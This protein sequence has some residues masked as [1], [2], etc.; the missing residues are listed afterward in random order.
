MEKSYS[1]QL[2]KTHKAYGKFA[3]SKTKPLVIVVHGLPCTINE[4]IYERAC[5]YFQQAGYSTYRF[6]LYDWH[7]DARQLIDCTLA[8]HATDLDTVVAHFRRKGYKKIFVAGHSFGGPTILLSKKQ[9]F[10]AAVLWDPSYDVS[11]IKKK[12]GAPGG[13]FVKALNGYFMR[14]GVSVVIGKKM[15]QEIDQ[16]QWDKLSERFHVPL[17]IIA[18]GRG[19]LMAGCKKYFDHALEPNSLEVLKGATH[20]FDDTPVMQQRLFT[21][22]H[23]WFENYI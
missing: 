7:K 5:E 16:L 13:K 8:I 14:W 22:T 4:G 12:Y 6:G 17:K 2:D 1:I 23:K 15:A 18:A 21:A 19:V 11:V 9:D 3:G 20:Y 10:D